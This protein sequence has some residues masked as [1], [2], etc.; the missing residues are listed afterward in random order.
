M[1][2]GRWL[3]GDAMTPDKPGM[4]ANAKRHLSNL[5]AKTDNS[6]AK[7]P[8]TKAKEKQAAM[9]KWMK[10]HEKEKKAKKENDKWMKQMG[11]MLRGDKRHLSNLAAKTDDTPAKDPATKAKEKKAAINKWMQQHEKEK[12]AKKE[13][14]KWMKQMGG[15]LRGDKRHLS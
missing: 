5:A 6:H 13:N 3:R 11:G 8:A 15:M 14:D 10:Q 7:D 1:G 4:G 2:M 12:K 9:N